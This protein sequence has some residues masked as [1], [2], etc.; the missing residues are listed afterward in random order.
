MIKSATVTRTSAGFNLV[1]VGYATS[2]EMV[3]AAVTF[4]AASGVTLASSQ[5]TIQL[6]PIFT[7]WYV[8]DPTSAAY[9]SNFLLTMPFT[10]ANG[11]STAPL[12]SVSVVLTNAQLNS[13][14]MSATY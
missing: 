12:T 10:I 13:N 4:T 14:S 11:T 8:A 2:R 1:V 9:G 5:A 7:T 3:S 6:G